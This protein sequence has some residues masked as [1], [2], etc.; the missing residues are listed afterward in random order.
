ME[1]DAGRAGGRV[2]ARDDRVNLIQ[3]WATADWEMIPL[4]QHALESSS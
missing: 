3:I 2:E 1:E 4:D